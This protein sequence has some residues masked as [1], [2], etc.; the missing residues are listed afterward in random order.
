MN[1]QISILRGA[2]KE[3]EKVPGADYNAMHLYIS[4]THT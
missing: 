4:L 3:L 1:Y 2:A